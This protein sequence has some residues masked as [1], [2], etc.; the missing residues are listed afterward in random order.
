MELCTFKTTDVHDMGDMLVVNIIDTKRK[1]DRTFTIVNNDRSNF[2]FVEWCRKYMS[3]R[4][5]C[6]I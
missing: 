6:L 1:I 2:K 5:P 3:L 4:K